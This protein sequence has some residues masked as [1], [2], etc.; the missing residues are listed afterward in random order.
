MSVH[1]IAD[2]PVRADGK[3][4]CGCGKKRK[5]PATTYG[6]E[7]YASDP[8]ATTGCCRDWYGIA[9]APTA[10]EAAQQRRRAAEAA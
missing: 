7:Q 4:A 5:P 9:R 3:C 6:L 8:F 1:Q 2:P 10:E